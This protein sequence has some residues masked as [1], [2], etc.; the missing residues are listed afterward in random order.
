MVI[1]EVTEGPIAIPLSLNP[2]ISS[3]TAQS[4][5]ESESPQERWGW[6]RT[7]WNEIITGHLKMTGLMSVQIVTV[8]P[9]EGRM[10]FDYLA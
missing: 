10:K 3:Q 8:V 1:L 6:N 7:R 2:L 9:S 5:S 4:S